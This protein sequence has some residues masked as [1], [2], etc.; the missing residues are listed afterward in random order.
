[1][2]EAACQAWLEA[3]HNLPGNPS[4]LHRVGSRADKALEDARE[5]LASLLGCAAVDVVWT[6]SASESNNAIWYHFSQTLP[7]EAVVWVSAIEHPCCLKAAQ[8]WFGDR[9]QLIPVN[10][11]G[12]VDMAWMD[13]ALQQKPPAVVCVMT[14]NNETGALQPW[15]AIQSWCQAHQIA[16]FSDAVQWL[17]RLPAQGLGKL[18]WVS[19]CGHKHGGPKGVGFLKCATKGRVEPLMVG[20]PQELNRRAGTENVAGILSMVAA[21]KERE[22]W[23]TPSRLQERAGFRD[24]FE[25][26]VLAALPGCQILAESGERLWNTSTLLMPDIDCRMRWV[27]KLDR[28]GFAVSTGSACSSG[29]EKAS[30]VMEA[31]GLTPEESSRVVRFSAGWETTAADWQALAQAVKEVYQA[32]RT[33]Q[34]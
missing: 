29:Q 18:D 24:G 14:A 8:R 27:V 11:A 10:A 12:V 30:H 4:S 22:D 21:F 6:S 5:T 9:C 25:Q 20:G 13:Q 19:G 3:A 1:M 17:G 16:Y 15:Q 32:A 23:M 2:S 7:S 28:K 26:G 31:M 34:S 33:L